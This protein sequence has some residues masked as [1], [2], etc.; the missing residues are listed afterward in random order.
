[1][2]PGTPGTWSHPGFPKSLRTFSVVIPGSLIDPE[3][4]APVVARNSG[5]AKEPGTPGFRLHPGSRIHPELL[6]PSVTLVSLG[7]QEQLVP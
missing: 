6:V 2:S 5:F 1:M 4:R 3:L 7:H